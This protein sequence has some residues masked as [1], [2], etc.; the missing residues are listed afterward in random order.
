M[1]VL[2]EFQISC[3]EGLGMMP[4]SLIAAL[5]VTKHRIA[6]A[7]HDLAFGIWRDRGLARLGEQRLEVRH[8]DFVEAAHGGDG[9]EDALT[10]H[11]AAGRIDLFG[12]AADQ[13]L[14]AAQVPVNINVEHVDQQAVEFGMDEARLREQLLWCCLAIGLAGRW[15]VRVV[16]DASA[17]TVATAGMDRQALEIQEDLDMAFGELDTQL[18]VPMDM[19]CAVEHGLD[20]HVAVG[21]QR[22]SFPFTSIEL[23]CGQ[24]LEPRV[25]L[26]RS[27]RGVRR[28]SVCEPA[29]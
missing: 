10:G 11:L 5:G 21:V 26:T 9:G 13:S 29:R 28:Q 14:C 4:R 25:P 12:A 6:G 15:E 16:E 17:I 3:D 22:C 24:R 20:Q 8:A 23:V 1:A 19:R 18:L 2:I 27:A 7:A